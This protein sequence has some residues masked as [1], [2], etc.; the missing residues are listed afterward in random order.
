[1]SEEFTPAELSIASELQR[2][3]P[4]VEFDPGKLG[5]AKIGAFADDL[6]AKFGAVIR[7]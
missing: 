2:P 5:Q 4:L 1:M 6:G 7:I 3:P